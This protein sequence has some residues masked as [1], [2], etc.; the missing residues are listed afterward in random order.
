MGKKI[1]KK[2]SLAKKG[3]PQLPP[4]DPSFSPDPDVWQGMEEDERLFV[5]KT[6]H[7]KSKLQHPPSKNPHLHA[8]SHVVAEN[9]I[10]VNEPPALEAFKRFLEMGLSR[11]ESIHAVANAAM[12]T[13][14]D[15]A[16]KGSDYSSDAFVNSLKSV[17][18]AHFFGTAPDDDDDDD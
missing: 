3:G 10:A 14:L 1:K 15:L 8:L 7:K 11:H 12:T 13:M 18:P 6:F 16:N 4:Y 17:D 9:L 2:T 5:V